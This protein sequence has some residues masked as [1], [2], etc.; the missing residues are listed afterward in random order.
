M[1]GTTKTATKLMGLAIMAALVASPGA[2]AATA[3][4]AATATTMYQA[5]GAVVGAFAGTLTGT[6]TVDGCAPAPETRTGCQSSMHVMSGMVQAYPC[7]ATW[8]WFSGD[9]AQRTCSVGNGQ[10][11]AGTANATVSNYGCDRLVMGN[12]TSSKVVLR[13]SE[14]L[15]WNVVELRLQ[16]ADYRHEG[17]DR[18]SLDNAA[19]VS[20]MGSYLVL[21]RGATTVVAS[22]NGTLASLGYCA[23]D[24]GSATYT[25]VAAAQGWIYR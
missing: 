23:S 19:G 2:K 10:Y 5:P 16:A 18:W 7:S 17:T 21:R 25:L 22:L 8:T 15:R 6:V 9:N 1:T 12:L 11:R 24:A 13:D 4:T 20:S 14:G 3:A